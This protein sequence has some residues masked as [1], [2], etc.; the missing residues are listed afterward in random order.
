MLRFSLLI[1]PLLVQATSPLGEKKQ[2]PGTANKDG[3]SFTV[4][5]DKKAYQPGED[6]TLS[7]KLK[8]QS[9]KDIYIGDGYFGPS[10]Q[11]VGYKR[12][13]ELHLTNENKAQL[14]FWSDLSTEGRTLGIRKVFLLKPGQTYEGSIYL[15]ASGRKEIKVADFAHKTCGG[16]FEDRKTDHR[17]ELGKDGRR[18]S[19]SVV[20]QV[21]PKTHGVW[22][23]PKGFKDELLW[24]GAIKTS[25]LAFEITNK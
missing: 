13:F 2:W 5:L 12:H 23:P 19:L 10:Y 20:Y 16:T 15:V 11:E 21:D 7:F 6:I 22:Q 25:P 4:S 8:N 14:Q 24:K 18:Y 1:G 3:L 17:H 9:E